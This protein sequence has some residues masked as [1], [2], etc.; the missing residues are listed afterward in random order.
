MPK[1]NSPM[2]MLV[3]LVKNSLKIPTLLH[4]KHQ[5]KRNQNI[6]LFV[7]IIQMLVFNHIAILLSHT[8]GTQGLRV[9]EMIH[10]MMF[11]SQESLQIFQG[12]SMM[13]N[14]LSKLLRQLN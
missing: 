12:Q 4:L 2:E 7:T 14:L 6:K 8:L 5:R 1:K 13:K 10:L 11:L 3:I 9:R